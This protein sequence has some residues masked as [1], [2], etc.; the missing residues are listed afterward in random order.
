MGNK[1]ITEKDFWICSEGAMPSQLQGTRKSGKKQSGELYITVED[2][3]TSSWIDF[4]C[5]KYM[6]LMALIAA[7]LVVGAI[8]L[9][10]ITVATGGLGLIAIGALA[11]L[12]GGII[13][14]VVGGLLC[15]QKV[16]SKRVWD[17]SKSNFIS[18]GTKTITG[19][20]SMTCAAGG[21]ITFAPNIKSWGGAIA[22]AGTSYA[23]SLVECAV[24]GAAVGAGGQAIA[25]M[26]VANGGTGVALTFGAANIIPNFMFTITGLR[27][28]MAAGRV[29]GGADHLLHDYGT[30]SLQSAGDAGESFLSG[31]SP[32]YAVTKSIYTGGLNWSNASSAALIMAF[33]LV[34]V[35]ARTPEPEVMPETVREVETDATGEPEAV[36][37]T[38]ETA[39]PEVTPNERVNRQGE[40]FEDTPLTTGELGAA[41]EEA[42][43]QRLAEQGY[44]EV[45][46]IQNNSGHGVDVIARNP[47]NGHV[48]C[49]EVKANTSR[50]S[51]AQRLGGEDFVTDRLDRAV[52]RRG[53]YKS[54]PNPPELSTDA[55][56]AQR[57][58]EDAPN[59]DYE[60]HRVPVD[61]NTGVVG[62]SEVTPWEPVD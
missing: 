33:L 16:A 2:K 49:V 12:A 58:I 44:T 20:C 29:A 11:G 38:T 53:H 36:R 17:S 7:V 55:A 9:G 41:G 13:G 60:I 8:V 31:A 28:A 30:D 43:V 4:G 27:G 40:A 24:T 57:W 50:L 34:G 25:P 19:N 10:V 35:R 42:V 32:E 14:A 61:R 47:S 45:L 62:E 48:R 54:P 51:E 21:R 3:A 37:S 5:K 15:G 22:F 59:V 6:L 26:L 18:Q 23:L 39:E 46:R 52:S 56:R 1:I